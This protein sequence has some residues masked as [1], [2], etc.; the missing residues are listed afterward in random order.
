MPF[1]EVNDAGRTRIWFE[2]QGEG[3]AIL[4]AHGAGGNAAIW[5][6]QVAFFVRQGFRC[7]TFDHRTFARSPAPAATIS[8]PQF[9][10]D[11]VS[12]L[13][14]AGVDR[15]HLVGQ[16]MG[17]FTV[18]RMAL[19][20]PERVASLTF[21]ATPGGLPNPS[22]TV[23]A[24]NLTRSDENSGDN[25]LRTM[26]RKSS[27]NPALMQ[28]YQAIS[29]FNLE[30]RIT[31]LRALG[32]NPVSLDEASGL[33]CPVLFIAGAEDPLFPAELLR[34]YL[35]HI[36]GS[37]LV[38]IEDSGHSPYFEQPEAFNRELLAHLRAVDS[39]N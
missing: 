39:R 1:A 37:R 24:A 34:T 23:A 31:S 5:Y 33:R 25:I 8:T 28:L 29:G 26:S 21:S 2:S 22:P 38:V 16:S 6:Q 12:V 14:A 3:P 27:T 9:R 13:D 15:A 20:V 19:D 32:R 7:I 35:P 36:P 30:F 17:G 18:L 11:A 4:F 10:D